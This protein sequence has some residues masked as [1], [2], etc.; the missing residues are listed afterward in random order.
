MS[1]VLVHCP[2]H[3]GGYSTFDLKGSVAQGD[4]EFNLYVN[5]LFDK[6]GVVASPYVGTNG[7]RSTTILQPRTIGLTVRWKY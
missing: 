7:Y 6:Y 2:M 1:G 4:Y 3:K 5:N